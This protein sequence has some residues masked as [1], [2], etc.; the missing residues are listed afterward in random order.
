M[1]RLRTTLWASLGLAAFAAGCSNL[2]QG[3]A[4]RTDITKDAHT[5]ENDLAFYQVNRALLPAIEA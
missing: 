4:L 3:A 1:T 5:L 2:P